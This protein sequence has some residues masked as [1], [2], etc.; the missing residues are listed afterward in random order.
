MK[1]SGSIPVVCGIIISPK[2]VLIAQRPR[3]VRLEYYWEFPGGKVEPGESHE[4][5]LRREIQ[6]ELGCEIQILKKGPSIDWS[7]DWG[8]IS[9][10]AYLCQ[11]AESCEEPRPLEHRA[12]MWSRVSELDEV[13]LAPADKPLV[14]WLR[15]C[16]TE[17][18]SPIL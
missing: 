10:Q 4:S 18:R 7:Y 17:D 3:H 12:L 16:Q 8:Q 9:L 14:A 1:S 6:E 13:N 5:A 11:L 2:G 15:N